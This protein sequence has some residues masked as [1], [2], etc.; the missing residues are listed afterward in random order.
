MA[1]PKCGSENPLN[2]SI[3][4]DYDGSYDPATG[5]ITVDI[6]T[7]VTDILISCPDCDNEITAGISNYAEVT[8]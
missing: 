7:K 3:Q 6:S 5:N 1:C 2:V 8:I 4:R